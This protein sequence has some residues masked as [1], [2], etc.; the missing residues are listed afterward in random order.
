MT[1]TTTVGTAMK[2]GTTRQTAKDTWIP[3]TGGVE[4]TASREA[5][6]GVARREPHP[7]RRGTGGRAA[8]GGPWTPAPIVK[9]T[10]A[11]DVALGTATA[12]MA[13]TSAEREEAEEKEA[14]EE[15]GC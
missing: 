15:E 5:A 12:W 4:T 3:T 1:P 7:V 11:E 9:D 10:T 13:N 2:A 14:E 8:G 6:A